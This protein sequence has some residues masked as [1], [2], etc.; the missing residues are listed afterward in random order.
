MN[1]PNKLTI[2]RILMIPVFMFL[3]L[4]N[5]QSY[6]TWAAIV[7]IIAS[8]TDTLDGYIARKYNLIT[9]L[10][11][12]LDPLADKAMRIVV[13][14]ALVFSG[15]LPISIFYIILTIDVV[16]IVGSAILYKK[17]YVVKSNFY[18]K[19]A[20]VVIMLGIILSFFGEY[21]NPAH[22]I[23]MSLGILL[24]IISVVSYDYDIYKNIKNSFKR[25]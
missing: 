13:L 20:A 24:I 8:L 9:N 11:K 23:I 5:S 17:D 18:G 22:I 10:G 14:G 2:V 21:V 7:F 3:L 25:K 19:L 12:V 15:A 4:Y 6:Q 1:L 16:L